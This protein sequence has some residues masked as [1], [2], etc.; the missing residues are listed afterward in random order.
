M[1]LFP[2]NSCESFKTKLYRW[3]FN[4]YPA[5]RRTGGRVCFISEDWHETHIK[6]SLNWTTRNYVGTVFGGSIYGATDPVY[7]LQLLKILGDKYIIWD[8]SATVKFISPI[9]NRVYAKFELSREII[10]E[11]KAQVAEHNKYIIHLPV[12]FVDKNAKVYA[13]ITKT[14]YIAN[15]EYYKSRS[16]IRK[17]ASSSGSLVD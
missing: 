11:I 4:F 17:K 10:G 5:Y 8:K 7:M 14:L 13:M 1:H 2:T 3:Y 9:K 6:L 16:E 12:K 15:K